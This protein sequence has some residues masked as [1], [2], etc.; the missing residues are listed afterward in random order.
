M[1]S[2]VSTDTTKRPPHTAYTI[3][4]DVIVTS[5]RP[6]L[7]ACL[8]SLQ[9]LLLV[10]VTSTLIA[11]SVTSWYLTFSASSRSLTRVA[12]DY[13]NT[14]VSQISADLTQRMNKAEHVVQVNR[15]M[16]SK[17]LLDIHKNT[18]YYQVD[19]KHIRHKTHE[20][21]CVQRLYPSV[22]VSVSLS[23]SVSVGTDRGYT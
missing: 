13:S 23:L 6:R 2:T 11:V 20:R 5:S 17:G 4:P 10:L 22:S 7:A 12:T 15:R 18:T 21:H 8:C 3:S 14:L 16:F 1:P 9:F 19:N